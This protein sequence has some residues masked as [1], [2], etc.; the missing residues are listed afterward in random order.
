MKTQ[1]SPGPKH[2]RIEL[3]LR[4]LNQLF[5]SIDPAPF[6]EKDLDQ[7]AEEFIESWAMEYPH[8]AKLSLRVH[9]EKAPPD[10][11][12]R[13]LIEQAIHHFYAMKADMNW[14]QFKRLMKE[15]RTSLLIGVI[16][17]AVC[18]FAG[19]LFTNAQQ[20]A[21]GVVRE[22]LLIGGW[23]AMWR[24]MEIFL[25]EWWPLLSRGRIYRKLSR[26]PVDLKLRSTNPT[27]SISPSLPDG[28]G[29]SA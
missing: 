1:H 23:V 20:A 29:P 12:P 21:Q 18:V 7:D 17:L 3:N 2:H 4:E 6:Y 28:K 24:P 19:E 14:L 22:S 13:Q 25:Y 11:D 9:L 10:P 15:G 16:C 26:M 27:A 5:N 8:K